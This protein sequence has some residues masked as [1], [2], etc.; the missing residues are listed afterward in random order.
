M[1]QEGAMVP[2]GADKDSATVVAKANV[3]GTPSYGMVRTSVCVCM[4]EH[5]Y[6][7]LRQCAQHAAIVEGAHFYHM[8]CMCMLKGM[9][10]RRSCPQVLRT[11]HTLHT[12]VCHA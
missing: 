5:V 2:A 10:A 1:E 8:V 7:V 3:G 6:H 12:L 11:T 9:C 4:C